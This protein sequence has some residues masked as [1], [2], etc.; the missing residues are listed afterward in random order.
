V[1][2]LGATI[3]DTYLGNYKTI[4]ISLIMYLLVR[5]VSYC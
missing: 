5:L 3:A 1:P 4:L 2:I